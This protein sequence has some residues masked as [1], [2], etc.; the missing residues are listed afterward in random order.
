MKT[1]S[2][3]EVFQN[4]YDMNI[5]DSCKHRYES[6]KGLAKDIWDHQQ[7]IIDEQNKRIEAY[8]H[9]VKLLKSIHDDFDE[10]TDSHW[11]IGNL[12]GFFECLEKDLKGEKD[13]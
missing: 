5:D 1:I 6:S 3:D 4:A 12:D 9:H 11:V 7:S 13:D 8:E 2:F 10:D